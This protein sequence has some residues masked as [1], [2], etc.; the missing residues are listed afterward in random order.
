MRDPSLTKGSRIKP[1]V[2][3]KKIKTRQKVSAK[4]KGKRRAHE[5]ESEVEESDTESDSTG[6]SMS[7]SDRLR[8]NPTDESDL[9][10]VPK[11]TNPIGGDS[12]AQGAETLK[13]PR[14]ASGD[15][16][17]NVGSLESR[18]EPSG[19]NR[20]KAESPQSEKAESLLQMEQQNS[21]QPAFRLFKRR[22]AEV[23]PAAQRMVP[24]DEKIQEV[25][26]AG[27]EAPAP[28]TKPS[29]K[30]TRSQ[31]A[32]SNLKQDKEQE[33]RMPMR[34]PSARS[35]RSTLA[36]K[37]AEPPAKHPQHS[38]KAGRSKERKPQHSTKSGESKEMKSTHS[39]NKVSAAARNQ[40]KTLVKS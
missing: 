31:A 20:E 24:Q 4:A 3:K 18:Q 35:S 29:P 38:T 5:L 17:P 30:F 1:K 7:S 8:D 28:S 10:V 34:E 12:P 19:H 23:F 33:G 39:K 11:G 6:W 32:K 9:E 37:R 22:R 15:N 40:G 13:S 14:K 21:G 26:P 2:T 16:H 27:A 36:K 25:P